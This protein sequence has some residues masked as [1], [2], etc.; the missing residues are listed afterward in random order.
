MPQRRTSGAPYLIRV[1]KFGC[2]VIV[3][4]YASCANLQ[5]FKVLFSFIT[6]IITS[7]N[8][9]LKWKEETPSSV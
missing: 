1:N 9:A 5:A 2:H 4:P 3:R 7:F 8:L 6:Q